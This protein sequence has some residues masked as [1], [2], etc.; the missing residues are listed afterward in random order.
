[1]HSS[2]ARLGSTWSSFLIPLPLKVLNCAC[3][4]CSHFET[5]WPAFLKSLFFPAICDG[6]L[7][8]AKKTGSLELSHQHRSW[9]FY[10]RE[11]KA[12]EGGVSFLFLPQCLCCKVRLP[13][14]P[15]GI[16][17]T[18]PISASVPG[19]R[20]PLSLW[21]E[22][23]LV[24][25]PAALLLLIRSWKQVSARPDCLWPQG[26]IFSQ[27]RRVNCNLSHLSGGNWLASLLT[28]SSCQLAS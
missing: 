11:D 17:G 4:L 10:T 1:M 19:G 22:R 8:Q 7:L 2:T 26:E 12:A 6:S 5:S 20:Q 14:A 23:P 18:A 27:A 21:R 24:S 15:P 9:L 3:T 25:R 13:W 28:L 16:V